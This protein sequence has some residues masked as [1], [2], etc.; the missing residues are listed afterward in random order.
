MTFRKRSA[1]I[2]MLLVSIVFALGVGCQKTNQGKQTSA[3]TLTIGLDKNVETLDILK[4]PAPLVWYPGHQITE[5][6]V[7]PDENM[8]PKPLLAE[9]WERIDDVTWE[10]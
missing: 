8:K 6:L 5:A 2:I 7:I 3:Q 4:T 10:V 9:S 1:M